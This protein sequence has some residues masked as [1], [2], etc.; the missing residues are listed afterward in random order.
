MKLA[1]LSADAIEARLARLLRVEGNL[2]VEV[3]LG[4]AELLACGHHLARGYS[5]LFD[6]CTGALSMERT[7]AWR[8]SKAAE[9]ITRFPIARELLTSRRISQGALIALHAVLTDENHGLV[10]K[11]AAGMSEKDAT[12]YASEL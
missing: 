2:V 5:S 12:A 4:L 10:L 6:Y 1:A 9:L 8:R 3:I 11:R 7:C